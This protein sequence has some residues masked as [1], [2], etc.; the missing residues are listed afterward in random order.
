M[1]LPKKDKFFGIV[2]V[3]IITLIIIFFFYWI[4]KH[5]V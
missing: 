2:G 4:N 5:H 1:S 3:T